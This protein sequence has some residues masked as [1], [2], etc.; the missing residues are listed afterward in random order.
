M[1][2]NHDCEAT[3]DLFPRVVIRDPRPSNQIGHCERGTI[4]TY[5]QEEDRLLQNISWPEDGYRLFDIGVPYRIVEDPEI[6]PRLFWFVRM[7]ESNCLFTRKA[8]FEA[9]GG[10]DER[11]DR[12][13]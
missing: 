1:G 8:S 4:D 2:G 3:F 9:V 13:T 5:E 7:F 11:F 6:R 12:Y 10:C